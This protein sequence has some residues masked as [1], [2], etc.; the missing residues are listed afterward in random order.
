MTIRPINTGFH[1]AQGPA[2]TGFLL[3]KPHVQ[4]ALSAHSAYLDSCLMSSGCV[5]CSMPSGQSLKYKY[6]TAMKQT[7]IFSADSGKKICLN[8]CGV[9]FAVFT[10]IAHGNYSL[11]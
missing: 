9:I 8:H 4:D 7:N 1:L 5:Q 3:Y 10:Y 11:G 6:Y 2:D